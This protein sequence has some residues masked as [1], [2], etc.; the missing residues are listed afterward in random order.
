MTKNIEIKNKNPNKL[1]NEEETDPVMKLNKINL[2][3]NPYK[4]I[5]HLEKEIEDL[6][7]KNFK[8][9]EEK[10]NND[11]SSNLMKSQLENLEK[12]NKE[13]EGII[14]SLK[15]ELEKEKQYTNNSLEEKRNF[16]TQKEPISTDDEEK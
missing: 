13:Y 12:L 1:S 2:K 15:I 3:E 7:N 10:K 9:L 4:K 14:D 11:V 8:L 16:S 6:K 5:D